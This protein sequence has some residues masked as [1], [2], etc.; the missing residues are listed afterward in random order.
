MADWDL[1]QVNRLAVDLGKGTPA[2]VRNTR[3]ALEV[4][5]A[6]VKAGMRADAGGI[7][8]AP[9]FPDS[10]TYDVHGL[11]AEIGPDKDRRQGAL[12]NILYFG[13]PSNGGP[14]ITDVAGPLKR[15]ALKFE[16]T[17]AALGAEAVL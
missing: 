15:E 3:A 17:L 5:A 13:T 9:S 11:T 7:G 4:T 1:S 2:L 14:V 6:A 12:G 8:H 16:A 10:I